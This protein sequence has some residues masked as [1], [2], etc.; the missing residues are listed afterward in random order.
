VRKWFRSLMRPDNPFISCCGEAD[1]YEADLFGQDGENFV[2]IITGQGPEIAGKP[3]IAEGTRISVPRTK[4][5][6]DAGN[7]TGHGIIF[8]GTDGTVFC[9]V[10]PALL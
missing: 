4:M 3:H 5:Q 2:A 1:G 9:Y 7:P 8:V 6:R 10:T